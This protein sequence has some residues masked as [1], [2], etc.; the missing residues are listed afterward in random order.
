VRTPADA[1]DAM[2][3]PAAA[4]AQAKHGP[5]QRVARPVPAR[6]DICLPFP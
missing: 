6:I 3:S 1:V 4:D 5:T 2:A